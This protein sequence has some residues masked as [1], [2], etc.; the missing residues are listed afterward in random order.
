MRDMILLE[1]LSN[2]LAGNGDRAD[3]ETSLEDQRRLDTQM[4]R[5]RRKVSEATGLALPIN[6]AR[7]AGYRFHGRA[8]I[9][10]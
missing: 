1:K 2:F 10:S 3:A 5:L 9:R 8:L 7:N 4:R 6:T